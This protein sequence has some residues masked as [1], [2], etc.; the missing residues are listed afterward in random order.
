MCK[1][2]ARLF[3]LWDLGGLHT[4]HARGGE[5]NIYSILLADTQV[6][7]GLGRRLRID[8]LGVRHLNPG[9]VI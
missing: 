6:S 8:I 7:L 5:K 9:L 3:G 4:L 2:A 1:A